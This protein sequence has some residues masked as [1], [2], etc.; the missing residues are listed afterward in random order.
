MSSPPTPQPADALWIDTDAALAEVLPEL[1]SAEALGIDT[2]ADSYYSYFV[3]VCLLQVS[4]RELDLVI[5]PLAEIDLSPLG[6]ILASETQVK[7]FHA[8][9][10]DVGLLHHQYGFEFRGLFD[11]MLAAQV[12]G[13]PR[14]GL[15]SLLKERF[16]IEQKKSYQT[17]D[18]RKRPLTSGQLHYAALDTHFLIPL[19]EQLD[20][21]LNGA[22]RRQEAQEDFERL[23]TPQHTER[24]FDPEAFRR[25]RGARELEG[26]PLRALSELHRYR[27]SIASKRDRSPHRVFS[28][29]V[30][31]EIARSLPR[32][33]GELEAIRGLAGWQVQRYGR[34]LL[35]LI[36]KARE[37]GPMPP[38]PRRRTR[39]S[40]KESE[41]A[42]SERQKRAFEALRSWRT[43]RATSRG[44]DASRVATTGTL[45][46]ISRAWPG[47]I[48]RLGMVP[49][50]SPY[51]VG[52]YGEEI[53]AVLR[54]QA[55]R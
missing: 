37:K 5:D 16:E 40:N 38:P 15:A 43:E 36:T 54:D 30:L 6:E 22:Q 25:V 52:E 49:G 20:R 18:W 2:E 21:E 27:E 12:L 8:G 24:C 47:D 14:P 17:S 26:I 19:M 28:D 3:K 32:Q 23:C 48:D 10:N 55:A 33:T 29:R 51:R 39:P 31:L 41:P 35:H 4:T 42:L 50:F 11:T 7:I 44:V 53:L 46:A 34:P 1:Q 9:G 45:K 13:L